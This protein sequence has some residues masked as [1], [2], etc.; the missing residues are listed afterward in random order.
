MKKKNRT[1]DDVTCWEIKRKSL[2]KEGLGE[3]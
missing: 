3:P 2:D 1:H